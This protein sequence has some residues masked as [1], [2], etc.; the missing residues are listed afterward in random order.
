MHNLTLDNTKMFYSFAESQF[1]TLSRYLY[2][3]S[4]Y[5]EFDEASEFSPYIKKLFCYKYFLWD[6]AIYT[7][8]IVALS[9]LIIQMIYAE[10]KANDGNFLQQ[11][12]A[13]KNEIN[14]LINVKDDLIIKNEVLNEEL[15]KLYST[16]KN[17][18]IHF[19]T[20]LKETV[21][22]SIKELKD[23]KTIKEE[24]VIENDALKNDLIDVQVVNEKLVNENDA[25]KNE[26]NKVNNL[27][28]EV[29]EKDVLVYNVKNDL[30]NFQTKYEE[31]V[32]ENDALKLKLNENEDKNDSLKNELKDLQNNFDILER[33]YS[34]II[35]AINNN[36]K[37]WGF[38]SNVT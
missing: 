36:E 8:I 1:D 16:Y 4:C 25:L 15:D 33:K 14:N 31:V 5:F 21:D 19:E 12:D 10:G 27:Q 22:I 17:Q 9:A 6:D 38:K 28:M 24:L 34:K 7:L 23:V 30:N 32:I 18:L 35:E 11:I 29:K 20:R 3:E 2:G 37:Y 13:L 26:L